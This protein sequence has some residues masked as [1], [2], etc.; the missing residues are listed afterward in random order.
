MNDYNEIFNTIKEDIKNNQDDF[1]KY[2]MLE[3]IY[4][5][6]HQDKNINLFPNNWYSGYSYD[7]RTKILTEAINKGLVIDETSKKIRRF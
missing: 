4:K 7:D 6:Q 5:M 3:M 2:A 1:N